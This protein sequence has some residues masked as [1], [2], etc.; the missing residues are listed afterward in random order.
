M[1]RYHSHIVAETD[2]EQ[3]QDG[4]RAQQSAAFRR[5][6]R[7]IGVFGTPEN[8][9]EATGSQQ[10]AMTAPV[11][12]ATETTK[13]TMKFV[14]PKELTIDAA[15]QPTNGAVRLETHEEQLMAVCKCDN[16][17]SLVSLS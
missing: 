15:P 6:A 17:C 16:L 5:L 1:R 3:G 2:Y 7:Y 12:T 8:E 14:L 11:L 9:H 13:K 10:I 4:D